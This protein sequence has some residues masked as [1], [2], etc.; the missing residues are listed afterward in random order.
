M[1]T[2]ANPKINR[3][4]TAVDITAIGGNRVPRST[5]T[6]CT[7]NFTT[8]DTP[9]THLSPSGVRSTTT[10]ITMDW[11]DIKNHTI[12]FSFASKRQV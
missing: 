8:K 9:S 3:A 11:K 2:A 1:D 12:F 7:V 4:T 10:D 5:P 6:K